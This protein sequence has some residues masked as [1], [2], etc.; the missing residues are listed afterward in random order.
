[1][2]YTRAY[3]RQVFDPLILFNF[4]LFPLFASRCSGGRL[5]DRQLQRSGGEQAQHFALIT[6]NGKTFAMP[7]GW[8]Y[9]FKRARQ[10]KTP[11]AAEEERKERLQQEERVTKA[12]NKRFSIVDGTSID[13]SC[14]LFYRPYHRLTR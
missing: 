4:V 13:K 6:R 10:D 12:F 2:H 5:A 3:H 14:I 9:Q 8:F 7:V 1:M 11:E